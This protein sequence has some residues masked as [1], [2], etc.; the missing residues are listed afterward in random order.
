MYPRPAD[1]PR[2]LVYAPCLEAVSASIRH[3]VQ[4]FILV[5]IPT[6]HGYTFGIVD[7]RISLKQR[8]VKQAIYTNKLFLIICEYAYQLEVKNSYA[9]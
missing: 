1:M 9:G 6:G 3:D 5:C 4:C 8:I 7:L 2:L